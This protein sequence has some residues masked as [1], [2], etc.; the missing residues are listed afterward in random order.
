MSPHADRKAPA[1]AG[2]ATLAGRS[3]LDRRAWI[4]ALTCLALVCSALVVIGWE[5]TRA[6]G[7]ALL[8]GYLPGRLALGALRRPGVQSAPALDH[9]LAVGLSLV[10][11][12]LLG[13]I[14]APS[15]LGFT[16]SRMALLSAALNAALGLAALRRTGRGRI[17]VA[18]GTAAPAG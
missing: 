6:V 4:V 10:T 11:T 1:A 8:A 13:A 18:A 15:G 7:G 5:P 17:P 12:M 3:P 2:R 9:V 16:G 14:A